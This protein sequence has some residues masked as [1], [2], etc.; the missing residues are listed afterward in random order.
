MLPRITTLLLTLLPALAGA[1]DL[2]ATTSDGRKVLLHDNG[3]WEFVETAATG[4]SEPRALLTL[5][6]ARPIAN[7][8][9]VGLR[10][11]NSLPAQVRSLVL[12]FTAYKGADLA[13]E[14][15]SR[16]FSNIKPTESQYREIDFRGIECN[17]VVAVKVTA[18]RNCH[19]GELTQY[20]ASASH[21][22]NLVEVA[23][24]DLVPFGK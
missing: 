10:L 17:E 4:D 21:C 1:G 20:S 3:S 22:L 15:V 19:V 13:F 11:A 2:T 16:G 14:T 9:R 7:G 24:S 18:A 6:G 5:E 23:P 12:R 8:C